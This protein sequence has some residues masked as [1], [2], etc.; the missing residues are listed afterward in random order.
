MTAILSRFLRRQVII[1]RHED[2]AGNVTRRIRIAPYRWVHQIVPRIDDHEIRIAH[3]RSEFGC[4]IR[5]EG[6][7]LF[8][9]QR[10]IR[11]GLKWRFVFI[12]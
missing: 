1:N 6:M 8:T 7:S 5:G 11:R 4:D 2:R 3:P 12:V 10:E 9:A